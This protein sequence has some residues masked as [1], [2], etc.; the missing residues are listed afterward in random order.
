MSKEIFLS[1]GKFAIV[2]DEDY[3]RVNQYKWHYRQGYASH[4]RYENGKFVTVNMHRMIVGALPGQIVDHINRN[5]L[6]NQKVNLRICTVG[7]NNRNRIQVSG[8]TS[9]YKGVHKKENS[10]VA[11]IRVNRKKI[12]LGSYA[13]EEDAAR[14][15]DSVVDYFHGEFARKNFSDSESL[16]PDS[17]ESRFLITRSKSSR[18]QG[19]SWDKSQNR[20]LAFYTL[21][22]K[23]VKVGRFPDEES[24]ARARDEAVRRLFG[25]SAVLNFSE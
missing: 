13:A 10:W 2:D 12:H 3:E 24:A 21:N 16:S 7:E 14:A 9:K 15:Y 6:D 23:L 8:T 20:W 11:S 19:V 1:Q 4:T 22:K 18:Y 17:I 5:K 25:D